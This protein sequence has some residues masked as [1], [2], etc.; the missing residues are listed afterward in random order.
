M[1]ERTTRKR[2]PGGPTTRRKTSA[3]PRL[4]NRIFALASPRSLGGVSLFQAQGQVHSGT[5]TNF[6]S[7]DEVIRRAVARLQDAGFEVLQVSP[8]TINIT[9]SA[10]TFEDT[11]KTKIIAEERPVIK[12]L[13]RAT[14][15]TFI[16]CPDTELPGLSRRTARLWP[17]Y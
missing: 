5:V 1:A 11:F 8:V 9:G 15:A 16:E 12:E 6:F 4:P 2:K 10:K 14:T 17:T 13:G 7:D 3:A